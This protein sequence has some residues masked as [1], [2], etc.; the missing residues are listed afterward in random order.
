M[1]SEVVRYVA[2]VLN[3]KTNTGEV[4]HG[5]FDGLGVWTAEYAIINIDEEVDIVP[6]EQTFI[7]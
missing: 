5:L 1:Y 7:T 2:F 3:V 6:V 4:L